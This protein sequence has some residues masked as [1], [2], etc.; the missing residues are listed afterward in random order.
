MARS[1]PASAKFGPVSIK[2]GLLGMGS[3]DF[4]QIRPNLC[5]DFDRLPIKL[6]R[7][8]EKSSMASAS[9]PIS[10]E[11][12]PSSTR[13]CPMSTKIRPRP[14]C[15]ATRELL[16]SMGWA[17]WRRPSEPFRRSSRGSQGSGPRSGRPRL[18]SEVGAPGPAPPTPTC[19]RGGRCLRVPAAPPP[20]GPSLG[21]PSRHGP[22]NDPP[23]RTSGPPR[24][25]RSTSGG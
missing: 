7:Y 20:F 18:R 17:V 3:T 1:A 5:A 12:G 14:Q 4:G 2:L 10:S 9:G 6:E 21:R 19:P 11:V 16:G 25:H 23:L 24:A 13:L 22:P 8:R 15:G